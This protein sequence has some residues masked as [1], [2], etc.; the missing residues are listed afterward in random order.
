MSAERFRVPV[1]E[2]S[3]HAGDDELL[4]IAQQCSKTVSEINKQNM[5]LIT[6]SQHVKTQ[7]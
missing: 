5:K 7:D 6:E 3:S 2:V 4:M 1:R